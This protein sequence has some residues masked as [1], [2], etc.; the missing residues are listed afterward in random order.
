MHPQ[1]LAAVRQS[2]LFTAA[3]LVVSS[4]FFAARLFRLVDRHAV[5]LLFRDQWDILSPKFRGEGLWSMVRVQIG[6]HR[7]GL[8]GLWVDAV[9]TA[10]GWNVRADCFL[11]AGVLVLVAAIALDVKRRVAGRLDVFD[12]AI[13]PLFLSL[14]TFELFAVT[15]NP[16]HG[17]L[18]LLLGIV[19][20]W[21]MATDR[22]WLMALAGVLASHTGF[23]LFLSA[24]AA[25]LGL[26]V[27][28]RDRS[29]KALAAAL[30]IGASLG[31]FF[32]GYRFLP[33][34][35]CFVFPHPR[36]GEY[37]S[38]VGFYLLRPFASFRTGGALARAVGAVAACAG[39]AIGGLALVR[40]LGPSRTWRIAALLMGFSLLL[41]A[42]LA[43][44]RVCTGVS[45]AMAS[46]YVPYALLFWFAVYLLLRSRFPVS[47]RLG[48]PVAALL[49]AGFVAKEMDP[50]MNESIAKSYSEPKRR[51]RECYLRRHDWRACDAETGFPITASD[52][53]FQYLRRNRLN[54]ER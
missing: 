33:A 42:N 41:G 23:A 8:G 3:A 18:P 31:V 26:L 29:A 27:A 38:F 53:G 14:A 52:A 25:V 37:F 39:L 28:I 4:G 24:V 22:W 20:A 45:G 49:L 13:A 35:E 5:D 2:G 6:P 30:V 40:A 1:G 43:V 46:R 9:Y 12:A 44:G 19:A 17:A 50:T 11:T 32:A 47:S 36:P 16:A 51:W 10:T 21:A 15:P 7:Q 54:V 48:V 34:V